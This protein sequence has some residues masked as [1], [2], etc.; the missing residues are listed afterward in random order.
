[1]AKNADAINDLVQ[2][3]LAVGSDASLVQ[4]GG[5]NTSV[6]DA[7]STRMV[8]KASG[9]PLAEVGKKAGWVEVDLP[10]VLEVLTTARDDGEARRRLGQSVRGG[11]GERVSTECMLHAMLERV[12]L[13]THPVVGNALTCHEDGER[14]LAKLPRGNDRP[15]LWV[16]YCDPGLPMARKVRRQIALYKQKHGKPPRAIF[17]ANHGVFFSGVTVHGVLV[18]QQRWLKR[19]AKHLGKPKTVQVRP[20]RTDPTEV[21]LAV[22]RSCCKGEQTDGLLVRRSMHPDMVQASR[23]RWGR[24]LGEGAMNPDQVVYCGPAAVYVD[25]PRKIEQRISRFRERWTAAPKVV[26]VEGVGSFI[27]GGDPGELDRIEAM[28]AANAGVAALAGRHLRFMTRRAVDFIRNWEAEHYRQKLLAGGG[29]ELAGRI[30]LVTGAASGLGKGIAMGLLKAGCCVAFADVDATGLA[31]VVGDLGERAVAVTMNVTDETSVAAGFSQVL[32]AWGG[33][34]IV[35]NAAGVAPSH[36]LTDFPL[37]VWRRAVEINLTGYFL[38]GRE[39]AR[40]LVRQNLGGSIINLSSKTGLEASKN[41]SVYNATKAAE[42]HLARGW[43]MELGAHG[44]R[45]N[46]IAPGNVF[47]G[48]KIWNAQYIRQRAKAKGIRPEEVIPH[49]MSL[50]ALGEE[51]KPT[52]IAEAVVF[53]AGRRARR[54]T[55][56]VLVVDGGQVMVR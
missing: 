11:P 16:S 43:A 4:V 53:L 5:G 18:L 7:Y 17:M 49:Y 3:S 12:G 15:P 42:V 44:I 8:I 24:R 22:R 13:H 55:G 48:S 40:V 34:D 36:P 45:V 23:A 9:S 14:I 39:A 19:I 56:Q 29:N 2:L 50:T 6:K 31:K 25:D 28:I 47:E 30:A 54:I 20:S 27:V 46:A 21:A 33:L 41:N 1:M 32:D 37:D 51:I 38:V 52:D 35:V 26:I 10:E